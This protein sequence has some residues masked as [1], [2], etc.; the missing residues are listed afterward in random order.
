MNSVS[1]ELVDDSANWPKWV[2]PE[3]RRELAESEMAL[4]CTEGCTFQVRNSIP[5]FVESSAYASAFGLQWL[6]YRKTQLDSHTGVPVSRRRIERC[7]GDSTWGGLRGR[8]V[9]EAGCGAG[10][11]TEVLLD[12]G[13]RVTSIDLSD[14]V[15]ANSENFPQSNTHRVAQCD[16]LKL[17]FAPR[18][19]DVVCCLGVI[20][21]TPSP[22]ATIAAL[23]ESV[24]PGGIMV[25]DHY[26][27]TL[28]WYTKSAPLFRAML[29][30]LPP[31]EGLRATEAI[32]RLFLPLHRATRNWYVGQAIVSRISPVVCY[33]HAIPELDDRAQLEW[34]LLDT[35]D[36]LTDWYKHFRTASQLRDLLQQM[37]LEDVEVF[38]RGSNVEVRGRRPR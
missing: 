5:R 29:K 16:I 18:Q 7:F 21:H 23:Y 6:R 32:V 22:E 9:L 2:C 3:H 15:E 19:F 20:Q 26:A 8:H 35:H 31:Q 37:R 36:S 34:A 28:S 13:A 12:G 24:K 4:T 38:D 27:P 17:P 1:D 30:R 33:Y 25:L 11:F 10:R 14:A